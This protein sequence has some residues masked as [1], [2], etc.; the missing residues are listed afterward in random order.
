METMT[1]H[2]KEA[3]AEKPIQS[4][5][6]ILADVPEIERALVDV[7]DGEVKI[8]FDENQIS[9]EQIIKRIQLEGFHIG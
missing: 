9:E 2:I 8:S 3:T 4:L 5:E 6:D 1:I 7:E